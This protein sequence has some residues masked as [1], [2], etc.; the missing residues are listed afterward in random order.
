MPHS[1]GHSW[2]LLHTTTKNP[3]TTVVLAPKRR[4][5]Y[6]WLRP[7]CGFCRWPARPWQPRCRRCRST[8]CASSLSRGPW[9]VARARWRQVQPQCERHALHSAVYWCRRARVSL[10]RPRSRATSPLQHIQLLLMTISVVCNCNLTNHL[11]F[12]SADHKLLFLTLFSLI[13]NW[14]DEVFYL[15]NEPQTPKQNLLTNVQNLRLTW[16]TQK[17]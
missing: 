10:C 7:L 13:L 9:G 8:A 15:Y 12:S 14:F 4:P 11:N 2:N 6:C 17:W 1:S 5:C 3:Q 16:K